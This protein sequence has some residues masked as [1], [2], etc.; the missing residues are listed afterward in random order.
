MNFTLVKKGQP[1]YVLALDS[2]YENP[3]V[4][5]EGNVCQILHFSC[6]QD[7]KDNKCLQNS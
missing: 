4:S 6:L 2:V 5:Q 7:N 3:M 1:G